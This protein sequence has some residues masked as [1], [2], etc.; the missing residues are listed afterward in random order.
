MNCERWRPYP[1]DEIHKLEQ[2]HKEYDGLAELLRRSSLWQLETVEIGV[3]PGESKMY[4][5]ASKDILPRRSKAGAIANGRAGPEKA[6]RPTG[7]HSHIAERIPFFPSVV[8]RIRLPS[9]KSQDLCK[10]KK[11][12]RGSANAFRTE[13]ACHS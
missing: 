5:V 9:R 12:G 4:I 2:E 13:A 6:Q 3:P 11:Y 1:E 7:N 8:S 10:F